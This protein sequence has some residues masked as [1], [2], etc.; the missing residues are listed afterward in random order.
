M[1]MTRMQAQDTMQGL[2]DFGL[3][4]KIKQKILEELKAQLGQLPNFILPF[5]E[6]SLKTAIAGFESKINEIQPELF[7]IAVNEDALV[8]Y[9]ANAISTVISNL[10]LKIQDGPSEPQ[11]TDEVRVM[12]GTPWQAGPENFQA[13]PPTLFNGFVRRRLAREYARKKKISFREALEAVDDHITDGMVLQAAKNCGV[14]MGAISDFNF[15]S[16]I[17][18]NWK[19][20]ARI[21]S[22]LLPLLLML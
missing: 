22:A 17:T 14:R 5:I 6:S 2:F 19:T 18:N 8:K 21:V 20:I 13:G 9:L 1:T 3:M 7:T 4:D 15:F 11:G 12:M 16:W 10:L